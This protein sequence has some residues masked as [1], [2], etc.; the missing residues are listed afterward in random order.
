MKKSARVLGNL[1]HGF[2]DIISDMIQTNITSALILILRTGS[3]EGKEQASRTLEFLS[4]DLAAVNIMI[5]EGNSFCHYFFRSFFYFLFSI[6][7][8]YSN[9]SFVH[10]KSTE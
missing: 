3:N 8:Y 4:N 7:R 1:A 9:S 5:Q 6:I 2:P 10:S